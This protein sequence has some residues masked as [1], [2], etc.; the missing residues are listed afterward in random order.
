MSES[1]LFSECSLQLGDHFGLPVAL[2]FDMQEMKRLPTLLDPSKQVVPTVKKRTCFAV[3]DRSVSVQG[4]RLI[5]HTHSRRTEVFTLERIIGTSMECRHSPDCPV[6]V[7]DF[8]RDAI[9]EDTSQLD[10]GFVRHCDVG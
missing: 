3:V 4:R 2:S 9:E 10:K 5:D 8:G 6:G 1:I 7:A